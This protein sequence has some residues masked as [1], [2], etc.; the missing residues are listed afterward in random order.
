[1]ALH[2][3]LRDHI[4]VLTLDRPPHNAMDGPTYTELSRAWTRVRDD[5]DIWV[6]IITATGDRAFT[7]GADLKAPLPRPVTLENLWHTQGEAL[8]NKGLEVWKPIIMAV[9]GLCVGGGMTMLMATDIR[10][11]AEHARF[12]LP[13]VRRGILP[14]AGGTQRV[15]RQLPYAIAMEMILLGEQLSAQ[16]ALRY[17]LVN[18]VVPLDQLLATAM[19]YAERLCQRAPLTVRATKELVVRSLDLCL[20]DGLR[21]E[22]LVSYALRQTEDWQEG[23]AAF[24][25]GRPPNFQGR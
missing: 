4:A 9:N 1:V 3:E 22:T 10:I 23:V 13:E 8:L 20:N 7:V 2:V 18:K 15:L 11:A 12:M 19:E 16:D 5:D 25:E 24:R 6:A 21:M 17:G 14:G